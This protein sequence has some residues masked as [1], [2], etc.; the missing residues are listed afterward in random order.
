[1]VLVDGVPC[2]GEGGRAYGL[3]L[4]RH[5]AG[6]WYVC[7]RTGLLRR[8]E[9]PPHRPSGRQGRQPPRVVPVSDTMQCRF[10]DG[11]WHLVVLKHLPTPYYNRERCRDGDVLLRRPVAGL[12]PAEA[13][14]H[15]GAAV[16]AVAVRRLK[17]REQRHYP[18]PSEF[19]T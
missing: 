9:T 18:I 2:S 8:V 1:V 17:R 3:P 4:H 14:R 16:Y 11:A 7:P 19:W 13:R 5:R 15:Y 12:T 10:L 6:T